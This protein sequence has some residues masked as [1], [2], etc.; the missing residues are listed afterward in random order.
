MFDVLST[1]CPPPDAVRIYLPLTSLDHY[2]GILEYHVYTVHVYSL[3][4]M[5]YDSWMLSSSSQYYLDDSTLDPL[6]STCMHTHFY[7]SYIGT[8][9]NFAL[10]EKASDILNWENR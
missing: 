2:I 1:D 5:H 10:G 9:G 6:T 7:V 8:T 4:C 3:Q